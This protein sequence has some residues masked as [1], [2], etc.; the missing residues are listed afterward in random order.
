MQYVNRLLVAPI[1]GAVL[2]LLSHIVFAQSCPASHP[3]QCGG[4]CFVDAAQAQAGGCS[5]ASASNSSD[6]DQSSSSPTSNTSTTGNSNELTCASDEN[7]SHVVSGRRQQFTQPWCDTVCVT[8][9]GNGTGCLN[10]EGIFV[11]NA[12]ICSDP[13]NAR[14]AILDIEYNLGIEVD[15]QFQAMSGYQGAP[16]SINP[17]MTVADAETYF[18][19]LIGEQKGK[20]LVRLLNTNGDDI[21]TRN[22]ASQAKGS[23]PRQL[24]NTG[25]GCGL[26]TD[27][28]MAYVGLYVGDGA[29]DKYA[30]DL[31][32]SV[33]AAMLEFTRS[34]QPGVNAQACEYR[35]GCNG[36][37]PASSS[38]SS[39]SSAN[40]SS[41][42]ST[43]NSSISS[44]SSS[45][46]SSALANPNC[47]ASHP[48]WSQSCSQCFVDSSQAASAGCSL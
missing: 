48:L 40:S 6:S 39:V 33:K 23:D 12:S 37:N 43:T 24:L 35:G 20:E 15:D 27:D 5:E 42:S 45:S 7:P 4:A 8:Y 46:V 26:S 22:E 11:S 30:G 21:V 28:I 14:E 2:L 10:A 13:A 36:N 32:D 16:P 38:A 31:D 9:V 25:F 3:F 44:N 19:A 41:D 47:P 17:S 29:I 1:A 34:W 18:S